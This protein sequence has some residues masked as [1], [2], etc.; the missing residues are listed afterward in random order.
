MA[1][2]VLDRSFGR[3]AF[4]LDPANYHAARP[5]YPEVV[6]TAL[7][8]RAGLR[9]GID[10]LEIGAGT[11]TATDGLL[12]AHPK[13]LTAVEPDPRLADFLKHRIDDAHIE[14]LTQTF[15]ETELPDAS[16]DLVVSA[17][18]FH[19]LEAR[20]ALR[21]IH[22][23]LRSQGYVALIWNM[24]G[25]PGRADPFHQ[26]TAHLFVGHPTTPS[27]GGTTE[28]PYGFDLPA[29]LGDLRDSGFVPDEPEI[30]PW[31]LTLDPDGVRRLYL[32]YSNVAALAP[33]ERARLLDGLAE[34]AE[35]E[36]GGKVTRNMTTSIYTARRR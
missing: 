1:T 36:F 8:E 27:G 24:F 16:Y 10:V 9:A 35:R 21:R 6:W 31:P 19:W 22:D 23:L 13:R 32:S 14:V 20:P 26:A 29:R 11:G 33:D 15:E 34:V 4:G 2:P 5:P 18:A 3:Q 28:A 7:R 30:H 12:A 17:T 25:D